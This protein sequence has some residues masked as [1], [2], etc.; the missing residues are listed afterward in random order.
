LVFDRRSRQ[1]MQVAKTLLLG[2]AEASAR[3]EESKRF[4]KQLEQYLESISDVNIE[5]TRLHSYED[6]WEVANTL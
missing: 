6:I 4:C 1:G 5:G 2:L 3:K